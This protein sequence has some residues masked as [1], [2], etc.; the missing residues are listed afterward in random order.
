MTPT[1]GRRARKEA[2]AP[3]PSN[4][5]S[6]TPRTPGACP[7]G[8]EDDKLELPHERDQASDSTASAPD[9]VMKQ[10]HEDLKKG[11]VD[12]DMRATPGL[13]A[14]QRARQVP[15]PGGQRPRAGVP[16]RRKT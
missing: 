16:P 1:R 15:G 14:E 13:D 4:L 12:T 3:S 7:A 5:V 10:A 8:P 2:T 11:M 6:K 9:P